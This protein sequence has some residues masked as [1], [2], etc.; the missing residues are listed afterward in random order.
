MCCAVLQTLVGIRVSNDDLVDDD[1]MDSFPVDT[2]SD[3][4]FTDYRAPW[5]V[6]DFWVSPDHMP[7]AANGAGAMSASF[8][9]LMPSAPT[10][11]SLAQPQSSLGLSLIGSQGDDTEM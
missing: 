5:S 10:L 4:P 2:S 11:G 3:L 8:M 6:S 7:T 1:S 9:A